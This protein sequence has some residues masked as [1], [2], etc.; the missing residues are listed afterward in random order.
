MSSNSN[1]LKRGTKEYAI[2]SIG[3]LEEALENNFEELIGQSGVKEREAKKIKNLCFTIFSKWNQAYEYEVMKNNSIQKEFLQIQREAAKEWN[4]RQLE[5]IQ[6]IE[7]LEKE[8]YREVHLKAI[9]KDSIDSYSAMSETYKF[10][11]KYCNEIIEKLKTDNIQFEIQFTIEKKL[12]EVLEILEKSSNLLAN[13]FQDKKTE[14]LEYNKVIKLSNFSKL[15]LSRGS[16][17]TGSMS[18]LSIFLEDTY[19]KKSLKSKAEKKENLEHLESFENF[20]SFEKISKVAKVAKPEKVE[21]LNKVLKIEKDIKSGVSQKFSALVPSTDTFRTHPDFNFSLSDSFT[22]I[23]AED[24]S[25]HEQQSPS[26]FENT[27]STIFPPIEQ[28]GPDHMPPS[29]VQRV[30]QGR[31]RRYLPDNF[32]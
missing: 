13:T 23:K 10:T 22:T 17:E 9:H 12:L 16:C 24:P 8:K 25:F 15:E 11:R 26:S 32:P 1:S 31:Y 14:S 21:K 29:D 28:E 6:K 7:I 3:M 5:L 30:N 20:E 19:K 18:S 4:T 2:E 27:V